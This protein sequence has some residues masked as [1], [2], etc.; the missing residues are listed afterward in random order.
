MARDVI[1]LGF[2][3]LPPFVAF[4]TATSTFEALFE[5]PQDFLRNGSLLEVSVGLHILRLCSFGHVFHAGAV[6][7]G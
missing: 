3:R 2:L 1:A 6:P 5:R 4:I 7:T